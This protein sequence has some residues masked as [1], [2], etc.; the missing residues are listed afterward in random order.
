MTI[1][2]LMKK[3]D[4]TGRFVKSG[5]D[6]TYYMYTLTLQNLKTEKK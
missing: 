6:C 5:F 2:D 1:L 4:R 3:G